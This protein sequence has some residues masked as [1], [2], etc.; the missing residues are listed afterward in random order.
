[1]I[2][3]VDFVL[4]DQLA[5]DTVMHRLFITLQLTS[6]GHT[7]Q[8]STRDVN[9]THVSMH[10]NWSSW[11]SFIIL[12]LIIIIIIIIIVHYKNMKCKD[13]SVIKICLLSSEYRNGINRKYCSKSYDKDNLKDYSVFWQCCQFWW[14]IPRRQGLGT[15]NGQFLYTCRWLQSPILGAQILLQFGQG[16]VWVEDD[17]EAARSFCLHRLSFLALS[18]SPT[19]LRLALSLMS[20]NSLDLRPPIVSYKEW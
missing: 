1:M 16:Q 5:L 8:F 14:L 11:F 12:I 18:S 4:L 7:V 10:C 15:V 2:E 6:T 19:N 20:A 9:F 13:W 17:L 3:V